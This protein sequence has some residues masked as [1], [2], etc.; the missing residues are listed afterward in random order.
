MKDKLVALAD[1]V[2][3]HIR[4]G[5]GVVLGASLESNIP[6]AATH[7]IIRQGKKQLNAIAPISDASTDMLIGAGCVALVTGAWVGNVSGGLGHNYRRAA[8]RGEPERIV[9][10]DHSNFSL[11]MAL[12]AGA[13][14]LPYVP[15][16]S[17]L[18]SDMV[19]SNPE[20]RPAVDPFSDPPR[21]VVL[22]PPLEPDVAVI[23]VPRAD[24]FGNSH[25]WGNAGLAQ[26]AALAAGRVIVLADEIVAPDVIASDPGRVL[27][28]G[29][30][31]TA[32][33]HVPA[34]VHP[35]PMVGRWRRDTEFFDDY[36]RRSRER[37]GFLAWLDEWVLSLPDHEAYRARL[38]GRLEALRITG[39]A[40]AA[41]VNYA[42]E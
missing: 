40:L 39:E 26:E 2:S 5:D 24:R 14:G 23:A 36:H 10:R 27:F 13:Y 9:V 25:H 12:T 34:G 19:G 1:A 20:F 32:V 28:P 31:V 22:V 29:F 33:C 16:R 35:S 7:E 8:E 18:G 3:A 38:G 21:P 11:A 4:D 30:R 15:V 42:A 37:S 17:L 6:F 41:P